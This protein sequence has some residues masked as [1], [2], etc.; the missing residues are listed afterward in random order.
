MRGFVVALVVLALPVAS[1]GA[2]DYPTGWNG[3]N[4]FQCELQQAGFG[5]VGPNPAA[6]PYCIEFDKRRQ[7]VT[8][9]GV[10]EFMSQEPARVAAASDKCFYFQ[11]DHWRG[12]I[13][14]DDASTKT[15]EWDGHYFFDK[16]RGEG[17]VWVTNFNFNGRTQDPGQVPGMPAQY[18]RY[19]GPG[20]GG[21][22]TRNGFDGP[23]PRCVEK[24]RTS[25]PYVPPRAG[26][27]GCL[28]AKGGM[29][30]RAVG[31]VRLG[32]AESRVRSL[33]GS[34]QLVRR[35]FLRWCYQDGT[36]I[37]VGGGSDRSGDSGA[38]DDDPAHVL[39]TTSRAFRTRG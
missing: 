12:S 37:R 15:Y 26:A 8:Q 25:P 28:V 1:A 24:A 29:S 39:L 11:S 33:L 36:S 27:R 38:G 2:A 14:Q 20:T 13:V 19:F 22:I 7:N 4:P 6:D 30:S 35:G 31:G 16:A 5:P 23:D 9:L 10:V 3:Q 32:D 17:G 18:A 34:P 21:F